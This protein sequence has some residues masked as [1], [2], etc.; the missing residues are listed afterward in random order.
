MIKE[1]AGEPAG[2]F[3]MTKKTETR[4]GYREGAGRKPIYADQPM[5]LFTCRLTEDQIAKLNALGGA[6]W[7]R[8]RIDRAKWP[9]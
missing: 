9:E 5:K 7:L 1:E 8:E 2:N 3:D 6:Q 4:G